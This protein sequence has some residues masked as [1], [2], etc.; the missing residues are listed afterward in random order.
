MCKSDTECSETH[1]ECGCYTEVPVCGGNFTE[2][3]NSTEPE[4]ETELSPP[5]GLS[6]ECTDLW[7]SIQ[8][9][10]QT[11]DKLHAVHHFYTFLAEGR[12]CP[13][14]PNHGGFN[15]D[16]GEFCSDGCGSEF[17]SGLKSYLLEGCFAEALQLRS[18]LDT[19]STEEEKAAKKGLTIAKYTTT[20][21]LLGSMCDKNGDAYYGLLVETSNMPVLGLMKHIAEDGTVPPHVCDGLVELGCCRGS[22]FHKRHQVLKLFEEQGLKIKDT[23]ALLDNI[24]E[25]LKK[26]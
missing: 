4:P 3:A 7:H 19:E 26:F 16:L 10:V 18:Q 11:C 14:E 15:D 17:I 9:T 20:L 8:E 5:E 21:G 23:L 2:A 24:K 22:A 13:D 12:Q 1:T 25:L 6:S